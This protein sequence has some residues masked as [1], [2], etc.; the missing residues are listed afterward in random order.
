[1]LHNS[2]LSGRTGTGRQRGVRNK[3][4]FENREKKRGNENLHAEGS[5]SLCVDGLYCCIVGGKD[6]AGTL[7]G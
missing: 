6:K 2:T 3:E 4:M 1:M 7:T 5:F